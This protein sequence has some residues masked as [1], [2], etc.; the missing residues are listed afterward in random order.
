MNAT[1]LPC[2][3]CKLVYSVDKITRFK[4]PCYKYSLFFSFKFNKYVDI[5]DAYN[6]FLF[7]LV[8]ITSNLIF[9]TDEMLIFTVKNC[10]FIS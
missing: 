3:M 1:D 6:E 10:T 4:N 7:H 9:V 5:K 2:L 8:C